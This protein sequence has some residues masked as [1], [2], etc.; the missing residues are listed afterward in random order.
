MERVSWISETDVPAEIP[1]PPEAQRAI[2]DGQPVIV[3]LGGRVQAL[4]NFPRGALVV[5]LDASDYGEGR[6]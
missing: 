2:L 4:H 1:V 3:V 5:D 6:E